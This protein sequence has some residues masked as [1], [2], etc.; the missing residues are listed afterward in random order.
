MRP[1][2]TTSG[3]VMLIG[4]QTLLYEPGTEKHGL[5]FLRTLFK[6]EQSPYDASAERGTQI[7]AKLLAKLSAHR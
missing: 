7:S 2:S 5:H 6:P 4:C 1:H 3:A